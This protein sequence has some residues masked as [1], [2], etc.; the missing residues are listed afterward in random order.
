MNDYFEYNFH[1]E[2]E[3]DKETISCKKPK[4][5]APV[6]KERKQFIDLSCYNANRREEHASQACFSRAHA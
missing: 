6:K 3:E 2:F 1:V 5:N 4:R